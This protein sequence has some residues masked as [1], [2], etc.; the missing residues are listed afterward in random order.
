MLNKIFLK[1]IKSNL[2]KT[3]LLMVFALLSFV[4]FLIIYG[5]FFSKV[6]SP[7]YNVGFLLVIL[8]ISTI[9]FTLL[10]NKQIL[11]RNPFSKYKQRRISKLKKRI[12]LAF[13]IGA[14]LPTV[15]VALFSTY[16]FSFGI[17]S[18]FDQKITNVLDQSISVGESYISEN[19]IQL[20]ETAISVADD[21]NSIYYELLNN[22]DYFSEFLNAQAELRSINEGIVFQRN[23]NTILAQT[24]L[25]F[26]LAFSYIPHHIIEKA[27]KGGP[28]QIP[29]DPNK[30]R[31]LI[32]LRDYNDTY[33]L[34]GK[35]IETKIID[36]ID[37]AN[38][39]A[40]EYFK[41]KNKIISIQIKFSIIF[42]LLSICL[43]IAAIIWGRI[44]AERIVKPIRSL[45][46]SAEKVKNGDLSVQVPIKDLKKDEIRI[47]SSSFNRM[48]DQLSRQQK[49]LIVAQRSKA[50]SDVA[51]RVAH[52]IKN[53]L[54][55]MSLSAERLLKKFQKE[56]SDPLSF[57]KYVNNI[58][59]NV[60]DIKL[61]VQEFV[62][63]ARLP[64]PNFAKCEIVSLINDLVESRK[65]IH[66]TIDYKFTSNVKYIDFVCDIS[67][68]NR[69][70][71]NLLLNSEEAFTNKFTDKKILINLIL[72][73][74]ILE[75][76]VQDN[77][78]GFEEEF[79]KNATEA[80]VT[81]K[82]EGTGLGL[83]IVNR[84]AFE[85]YADIEVSNNPEGGA[86]IK[87]TFNIWELKS[88]LK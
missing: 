43:L 24:K 32:K 46:I 34:I 69:M 73:N 39:T 6:S 4:N 84:I 83:A 74:D 79:L 2:N 26:S 51:R 40:Q 41:L 14:A 49:E 30:I 18:W 80:Y 88:K 61:I 9:L 21:L 35:L 54:T 29:S 47:L 75:I 5:V 25:S 68:I 11:Y 56:S 8:T 23:S 1:I 58:L 19:T 50:W 55:P 65:M 53:P 87:L 48:I 33:L 37:K 22:P 77:G 15:I 85:H 57:E 27:D 52:E 66:D 28:V 20:K 70:M 63:F 12:I 16:I 86:K 31:I 59:N 42:I 36:H 10:L 3:S 7:F 45:V 71:V 60:R 62:E 76:T 17:S 67:Q 38:G 72:N 82:S 44:F 78:S 13:S 64:P 81:T